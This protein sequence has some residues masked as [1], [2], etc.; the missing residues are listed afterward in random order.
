MCR[1]RAAPI[2]GVYLIGPVERGD[3]C[4]IVRFL[5]GKRCRVTG[6]DT[7]RAPTARANPTLPPSLTPLLARS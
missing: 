1:V 3:Q 5:A 4:Q 7:R 2:G 6:A